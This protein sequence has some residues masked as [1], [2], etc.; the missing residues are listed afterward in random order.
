MYTSQS[1][2]NSVTMVT[3]ETTVRMSLVL[4]VTHTHTQNH[5]QVPLFYE[6]ILAIILLVP[7]L[8]GNFNSKSL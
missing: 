3:M 1:T 8:S 4:L 5:D 6:S 2:H 7:H